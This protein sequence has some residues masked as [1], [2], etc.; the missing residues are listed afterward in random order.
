MITSD[1]VRLS[2][3]DC[4]SGQPVLFVSGYTFPG[5]SW[6]FQIK[7]LL[8]AGYRT[9]TLDRR[10]HGHSEDTLFGQRMSRHGKDLAEFVDTL[11]L[12]E[13]VLVGS[14]M[15]ASA[16]WAAADLGQSPSVRG[17]VSVDQSPKIINEAGWEYGCYGVTPQNV[18]TF[19]DNGVP[20]SAHGWTQEQGA[21]RIPRIVQEL[22]FEPPFREFNAPETRYLS[23]DHTLQDWRDVIA[24]IS[25][26]MLFVAGAESELWSAE[27]ATASAALNPLASACVIADAGHGP[28]VDQPATFNEALLS[29][30]A[31]I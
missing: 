16:M 25:V 9:L 1:G 14:S 8:E 5:E 2:Y 20:E 24:R 26:P 27:H 6:V 4:G 3:E 19:F 21:G 12:W 23:R 17:Y 22:G 7:A 15:G 31:S 11:E 30:L 18:M 28:H 29:F 13:V 10:S